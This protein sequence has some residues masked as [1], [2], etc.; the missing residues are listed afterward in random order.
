M[1]YQFPA[2]DA[3]STSLKARVRINAKSFNGNVINFRHK[4]VLRI[5]MIPELVNLWK[6]TPLLLGIYAKLNSLGKFTVSSVFKI[7]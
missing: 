5:K 4:R 1:E 6:R 3:A 7:L 2:L